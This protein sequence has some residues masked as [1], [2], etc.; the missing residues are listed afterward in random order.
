[1]TMNATIQKFLHKL[2]CKLPPS[3]LT[4]VDALIPRVKS[5]LVAM[6]ATSALALSIHNLLPII[7][8]RSINAETPPYCPFIR[9]CNKRHYK[10]PQRGDDLRHV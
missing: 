10:I 9:F 4:R 1:M 5:G 6:T 7:P 3:T 8:A 2:Q